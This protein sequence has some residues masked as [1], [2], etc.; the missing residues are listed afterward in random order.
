MQIPMRPAPYALK[1][2]NPEKMFASYLANIF[3]IVVVLKSGY[4]MLVI[5]SA[6]VILN[7]VSQIYWQNCRFADKKLSNV[8]I[9]HRHGDAWK[10]QRKFVA[11]L[12]LQQDL[13]ARVCRSGCLPREFVEVAYYRPWQVI[14][15]RC[16]DSLC[17]HSRQFLHLYLWWKQLHRAVLSVEI[18]WVAKIISIIIINNIAS[19]HHH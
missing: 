17:C 2:L 9:S 12:H 1:S 11:Q 16:C 10:R 3:S 14:F 8:Q 7:W 15:A 6:F 19:I 5:C 13:F 4:K 18:I